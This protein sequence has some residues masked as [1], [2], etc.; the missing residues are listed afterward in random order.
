MTMEEALP[1]IF[2]LYSGLILG[3]NASLEKSI[4][5]NKELCYSVSSLTISTNGET[6]LPSDWQ[7]L[8]LLTVLNRRMLP[9]R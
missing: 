5:I 7:Y 4:L 3:N 2:E 9:S 1:Q 6:C 8:P